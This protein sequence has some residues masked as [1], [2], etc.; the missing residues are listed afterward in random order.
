M[1][2]RRRF[3]DLRL[4]PLLSYPQYRQLKDEGGVFRFTGEI[5]SITDGNT[6]W[7][8]G[9]NLTI[10]VSLKKTKCWLLPAHDG[11]GIPEQPEQV[12]WNSVSTLSEGIKVFIGGQIK[13]YDGRLSFISTKERPLT[14]IFYNC[15]DPALTDEITRSARTRNE[16]WNSITPVSI[17][18]GAL[19]LVYIAAYFLNRPAYRLTTITALVAI[20]LPILPMFPP[21]LLLTLVYRRI[22][23]HARKLRAYWDI[24][25]LPIRYLQHGED[26]AVLSTGEK[27]GFIKINSLSGAP[28]NTPLLIPEYGNEENPEWHFFGVLPETS[29]E[30]GAMPKKS[31]ADPFVSYGLL[32][33]RPKQLAS[34]YAV[35]AYTMEVAAWGLLLAGISINVVFIFVILSLLRI[36]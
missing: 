1:R 29:D 13:T 31:S 8:R 9:E 10:P 20:F 30:D 35:K 34:C 18:I 11:D 15:P 24:V 19:S 6:L 3:N 5:D 26:S 36:V 21:G 25:R 28:E 33:G 17:V 12:R 32:H 16:Y 14:V 7:V 27:Y 4:N 2:F 22:T 23:W